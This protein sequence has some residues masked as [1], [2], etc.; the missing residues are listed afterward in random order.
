MTLARKQ[1]E[2]VGKLFG[3]DKEAVALLQEVPYKGSLPTAVPA[4][5]GGSY[6]ATRTTTNTKAA[7]RQVRPIRLPAVRGLARECASGRMSD[8]PM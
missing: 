3:L 6:P 7:P 8:A 5:R 1:A 4:W 2:T